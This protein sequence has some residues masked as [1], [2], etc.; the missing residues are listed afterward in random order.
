MFVTDD[1]FKDIFAGH[2]SYNRFM[3]NASK[4]MLHATGRN[5]ADVVTAVT[6]TPDDVHSATIADEK[7]RKRVAQWSD[8]PRK[9]RVLFTPQGIFVYQPTKRMQGK[10][11]VR[12]E[13]DIDILKKLREHNLIAL[14]KWSD[15]H[16][17]ASSMETNPAVLLQIEIDAGVRLKDEL[18][19]AK[20]EVLALKAKVLASKV[21]LV[22]AQRHIARLMQPTHAPAVLANVHTPVTTNTVKSFTVYTKVL[23]GFPR[24]YSDDFRPDIAPAHEW[25]ADFLYGY[26]RENYHR[27]ECIFP[28]I[29]RIVSRTQRYGTNCDYGVIFEHPVTKEEVFMEMKKAFAPLHKDYAYFANI[30]EKFILN[31]CV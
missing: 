26:L 23:G 21:E 28:N 20:A 16:E 6:N 13:T 22:N 1:V 29:V 11:R 8:T 19:S 14:I 10:N 9:I 17:D 31:G 27:P 18:A 15:A 4:G 30:Y 2:F 25:E 5:I 24:D 7:G 3:S 12:G